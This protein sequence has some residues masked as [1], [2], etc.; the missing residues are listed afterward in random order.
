MNILV[1]GGAGYVGTSLVCAL[2]ARGH[3]VTVVDLFWFGNHLPDKVVAQQRDLMTL[4]VEELHP[5][6]VVVFLAGLSN[7]PMADFSPA[8][9]FVENAAAPGYLCYAAKKAGVR[10]FV[11]ASSCSVYGF[12]QGVAQDERAPTLSEYPYGISKLHGERACR[13]LA[14][15]GFSVIALRKG[16]V[17]G[18]S[19]RM[20]F[21]LLL[22]T[23][24]KTAMVEGLIRVNNPKIWRPVL[25]MEDAVDAYVKA[26][27]A[28]FNISGTF[29]VAST[30][31]TV[32]QAAEQ[33]MFGLRK[34]LDRNIR[35][36]LHQ[37]ED[38]RNY[39]VDWSLIE[40]TLN[41]NPH[42]NVAT[43]VASLC[44]HYG[45]Q[46][47]F[48]NDAYYNIRTFQNLESGAMQANVR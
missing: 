21:D 41:Y 45:G 33:V 3:L 40:N 8:R 20:R 39:R 31:V 15:T 27:E 18:V 2:M 5:F 7:D 4:T 24:F 13:D 16:T 14:G 43:I 28:P 37:R 34:H 22:N 35:L 42:H 48:E 44:R 23:M 26:I 29:N 25:A 46:S 12:T 10:R 36:E 9:N 47:N 19:P 30:N 17:C 38:V 11:Y 1:A 32:G 6:D